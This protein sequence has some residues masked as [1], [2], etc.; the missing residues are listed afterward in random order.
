MGSVCARLRRSERR[1]EKA[2]TTAAEQTVSTTSRREMVSVGHAG[3]QMC[4]HSP[5][6]LESE[7]DERSSNKDRNRA[8]STGVA[9][10]HRNDFSYS[11]ST[12]R[13]LICRTVLGQERPLQPGMTVFFYDITKLKKFNLVFAITV[14]VYN[15]AYSYA[16]NF[17]CSEEVYF[18]FI[19]AMTV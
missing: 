8:S 7:G 5:V 13:A 6:L 1:G 2:D 16:N 9:M 17:V 11:A 15:V 14:S 10:S 18:Y 19:F 4:R 3:I 12:S